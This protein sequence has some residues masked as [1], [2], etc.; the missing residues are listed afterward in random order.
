MSWRIF[1]THLQTQ[2]CGAQRDATVL[3]TKRACGA[4]A[5]VVAP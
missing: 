4:R 5:T 1:E 2:T 3:A